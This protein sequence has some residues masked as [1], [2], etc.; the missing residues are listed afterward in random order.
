MERSGTYS[1]PAAGC[2]SPGIA[3]VNGPPA[4]VELA[5]VRRD[6]TPSAGQW[7]PGV[8]REVGADG[9]YQVEVPT[10]PTPEQQRVRVPKDQLR[11]PQGS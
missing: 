9:L 4:R 11:R 1:L 8:I 7:F 3:G 2:R 6:S 10:P 5:P